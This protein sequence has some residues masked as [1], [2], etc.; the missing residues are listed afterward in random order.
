MKSSFKQSFSAGLVA[1]AL[2]FTAACSRDDGKSAGQTID[3]SAISAKVKTAFAKDPGVRAVDIKVDTHLGA[4]QLSGWADSAEEKTKAETIAKAVP[5]VK[6]VDNKI[7]LK[8][9]VKK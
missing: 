1:A 3:D 6:S 4:V 2:L 8:T 5:G 9:N 7:E